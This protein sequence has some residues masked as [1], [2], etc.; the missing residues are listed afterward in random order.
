MGLFLNTLPVRL[1]LAADATGL[2]L[3]QKIFAAEQAH[4]PHRRYPAGRVAKHASGQPAFE[5]AFNYNHFHVYQ[6]LAARADLELSDPRIFEYTNFALLVNFDQAPDGAGLALR[7]NYDAG[8]FAAQ[9]I[10]TWAGYYRRALEALAAAPHAP[11]TRAQ[12]LGDER[13][14]VVGRFNAT[15]VA[16]PAGETLLTL[17]ARQVARTPAGEAVRFEGES[18]TY[19]ELDARSNQL[20]RWLA[21]Q[22]VGP[23]AV[24]GVLAERSLELLVALYGVLKA[25]AA[26][27]PLEP[28]APPQ[29]LTAILEEARPAAVLYQAGPRRRA[30][31]RRD[32]RRTGFASHTGG[33]SRVGGAGR[34]AA[35]HAAGGGLEAGAR[36]LRALHVGL[37][38]H[39]QGGAGHARGDRQP[40]ALDA[41]VLRSDRARPRAAKNPDRL[42]RLALGAVLALAVRG[43]AGRGA[44]GRPQGSRSTSPN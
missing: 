35:G 12:L 40:A 44:A 7:L 37:D 30:S 20:G 33:G 19:A 4:L 38:G 17:F 27:L 13:E 32:H 31:P 11:L 10:E 15:A 23:E 24:V 3:I 42:R 5:A 18:L 2:E 14:T 26:W 16:Y 8:Q 9:Q 1:Q 34:G 6:A 25:G 29:R 22:G 41:G 39:A 21:A 36:G 28:D 43:G